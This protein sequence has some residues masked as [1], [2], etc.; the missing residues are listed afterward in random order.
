MGDIIKLERMVRTKNKLTYEFSSTLDLFRQN[1]FFIEYEAGVISGNDSVDVIPFAAIMAPISWAAG[2][3][4]VIPTLD[5]GYVESLSRCKEYFR[6]WFS[7]KWSFQSALKT[8]PVENRFSG[9]KKAMLFSSGLDSLATYICHKNEKPTLFT[10]FGADIPLAHTHFIDLCRERFINFAKSHGAEISFV[11]TDIRDVLDFTKLK[12]YSKGWYGEVA[13]GLMMSSLI[14]PV[15]SSDFSTLYIASCS[16]RPDC[17]YPCGSEIHLVQNIRWGATSIQNDNH[18]L[19]R[20]QKI[21]T[22]LKGHEEMYG[23]LR[24]CWAQFESY[25]C[26]KCE[27]CLRTICELLVSNID[28]AKCNFTVTHQTL[29]RLKFKILNRYYLFFKGE[30]TLD[31]WRSIQDSIDLDNLVDIY[32]SKAFFTWFKG[33][34]KLQKRQ[35]KLVAKMFSFLVE[36]K[37]GVEYAGATAITQWKKVEM[38]ADKS[39]KSDKPVKG[40]SLKRVEL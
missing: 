34:K 7:K 21:Q 8:A 38:A 22:F 25:N 2:A 11:Y 29:E 16:H 18:E 24:V 27:K 40:A 1:S 39:L 37:M 5:K 32:G 23:D 17:S 3:D 19:N 14:A 13:H 33:F 30:S 10:I 20:A 9:N 12:K 6:K 31:F 35:N 36:G 28:P 15:G 26:S 4:L